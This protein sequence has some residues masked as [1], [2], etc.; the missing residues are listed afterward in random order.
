MEA[1]GG[2][3]DSAEDSEAGFPAG[4][5]AAQDPRDHHAEEEEKHEGGGR[6]TRHCGG[7]LEPGEDMIE[8]ND[9]REGAP[10]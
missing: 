10:G 7:E 4:R 3:G 9:G 6:Q 1:E 5:L 2:E 8:R